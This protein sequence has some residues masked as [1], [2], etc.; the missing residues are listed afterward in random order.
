M[1]KSQK[2]R[3]RI[4]TSSQL[5]ISPFLS[6][7]PCNANPDFFLTFPMN[8]QRGRGR[9]LG[10]TFHNQCPLPNLA[11]ERSSFSPVPNRVRLESSYLVAPRWEKTAITPVENVEGW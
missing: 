1:L 10:E 4:T 7:L 11:S 3:T 6:L 9:V 8:I 5:F 2:G